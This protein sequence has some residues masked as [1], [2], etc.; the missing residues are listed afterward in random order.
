METATWIIAAASMLNAAV[1]AIY[2]Y[3]TWGD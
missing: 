3:F 1:L 2:A